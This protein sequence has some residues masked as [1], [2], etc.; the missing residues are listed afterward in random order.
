MVALLAERPAPA[1]LKARERRTGF[2]RGRRSAIGEAG[3]KHERRS[4]L[5]GLRKAGQSWLGKA[6]VARVGE[7]EITSDAVRNAYQTE[8]QRLSRQ[9]RQTLTPEQARLLGLDRQVLDRLISEA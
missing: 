4:M 2:P 6:V 9:T 3:A 1:N 8:L 5:T 7:T